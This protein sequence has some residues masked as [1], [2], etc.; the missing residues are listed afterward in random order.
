MPSPAPL[1]ALRTENAN[2]AEQLTAATDRLTTL[3]ADHEAL[4][5][6]CAALKHQLD[7]FRRQLFGRRSEKQ[8]PFDPAEQANLFEALG[9]EPEAAPVAVEEI[10]YRRRKKK[11]R[12]DAATDT[13]LRFDASVPV[14]T[15]EVK[16][17]AVEAIPEAEREHIGEKVTHRL[18]QRPASYEVLKYVRPVVKRRDSGELVTARMPSNVLERTAAD[19]SLLAGMLVDKFSHHLPLH[20]QHRRMGD[21]G[22]AVSRSSVTNWTGRAIDLLKPVMDA[23]SAH[24]LES[25]VLAM[26]ET[27]VKAG[28]V[29]PG[30]M[31]Q[32]YFWPVYGEDDEIVFH[33][34]P[35]REHRHVEAFL[36]NFKGTLLSDG[37]EAYAS[38]AKRHGAVHAQC[39]AHCRRGFEQA[40]ESAPAATAAALALIGGLYSIERDIRRARVEG[41]AKRVIRESRSAPIAQ[42]FFAWCRKQCDRVDLLPKS[43]LAKA[44]RYALDREDGLS[45]FL[46][47]PRV[48]IDTNHLERGLRPVPLGRRNWLFAWTELGAERVGVIQSLLATCRLHGVDPY[49]YLVDVLQRVGEHPASRAVE[50][51]PRLWKTLFAHNPLRS[52]LDSARGPPTH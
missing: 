33:Y 35:T 48:A 21:A 39:W 26:D 30:K 7:W 51:T 11:P 36:G 29:E 32:A 24:V 14:T 1:A 31:R 13:G 49:T 19:V 47:D 15:I 50:L 10:S 34:A 5:A 12:G 52:D 9:V 8:T 23:Q 4:K 18:A 22:I 41:A 3:V 44:L 40:R 46:T 20:R 38:Y 43:P 27:A 17:P 2:L 28:R 16:D 42:E 6:D 37:Y 25:R 45:V